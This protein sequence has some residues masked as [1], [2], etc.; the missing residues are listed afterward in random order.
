[1]NSIQQAKEIRRKKITTLVVSILVIISIGVGIF[2]WFQS[3]NQRYKQAV[4]EKNIGRYSIAIEGFLELGS[5]KDSAD[6]VK[7]CHYALGKDY[8]NRGE[9]ESAYS[10]FCEADSYSDASS[11]AQESRYRSGI[12]SMELG[13]YGSAR[14]DFNSLGNY[15]DSEDRLMECEYQVGLDRYNSGDYEGAYS[16]WGDI[17]GYRDVNT[18]LA[19]DARNFF[20]VMSS[21]YNAYGMYAQLLDWS[22]RG[23]TVSELIER[24]FNA[25]GRNADA[26]M[27]EYNIEIS[28]DASSPSYT[29]TC[30]DSS[31]GLRYGILASINDSREDALRL[32]D[33]MRADASEDDTFSANYCACGTTMVTL[34]GF[35][36][37][38]P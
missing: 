11:R 15:K 1:M 12:A 22:S 38:M 35:K 20:E 29:L 14:W 6:Q 23:V 2:F 33:S 36:E 37:E 4:S 3:Q 25:V 21:Q 7:E 10:E 27:S 16:I 13:D 24:D 8:F 18:Y 34:I 26:V 5:Y 30:F 28:F 32:A 19:T 9:Y 31:G 17:I